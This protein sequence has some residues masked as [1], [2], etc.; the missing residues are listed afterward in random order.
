MTIS[1]FMNL[2]DKD[3]VFVD[4]DRGHILRWLGRSSVLVEF[5][6]GRQE[7]IDLSECHRIE[8]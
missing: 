1:E 8:E 2:D 4:G 5:D 6:S 3:I 7:R